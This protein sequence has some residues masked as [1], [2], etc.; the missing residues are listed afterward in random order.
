[1]LIPRCYCF[2]RVRKEEASDMDSTTDLVCNDMVTEEMNTIQKAE[3]LPGNVAVTPEFIRNWTVKNSCPV[4]A[5]AQTSITKEDK[6]TRH[7]TLSPSCK[8]IFLNRSKRPCGVLVKA[9][10]LPNC[11]RSFLMGYWL[12]ASNN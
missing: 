10:G 4:A 1:V 5:A 7:G 11:F 2:K 8:V 3:I 6:E 9:T 12:C